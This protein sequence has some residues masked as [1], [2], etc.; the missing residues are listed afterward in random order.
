MV[1]GSGLHQ[2]IMPAAAG[3]AVKTVRHD[4]RVAKCYGWRNTSVTSNRDFPD[5]HPPKRFGADGRRKSVSTCRHAV[6][7]G[8]G[9]AWNGRLVRFE[10][11]WQ[12]ESRANRR[13][14]IWEMPA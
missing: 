11:E 12:Q 14:A 8:S 7:R 1:T 6:N 2:N 13:G 5:D 3:A 4:G 10:H 9:W